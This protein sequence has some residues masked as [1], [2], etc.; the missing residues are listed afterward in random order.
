[1][2]EAAER[3]ASSSLCLHDFQIS[4]ETG[5]LPSTPPLAN[6]PGEH[7]APW[8]EVLTSLPELNRTRQLRS[9]VHELP[10]REFS[11]ATLGSEE[12]WR[13][14]YVVLCFIGQSYIWG[15]GQAGLVDTIPKKL[16]VPWCTVSDHLHVKPVVCYAITVLYNFQLREP[17]GPWD[18]ENI[19]I[20]NTFTGSED[21]SWFYV[22]P[23]LIELAAVPGINAMSKVFADMAHHR[24]ADILNCLQSVQRSLQDMRKALARMFEKCK[25]IT[26]YTEIR[27][28][29]AGT[30]GLDVLPEGILFEGV[31]PKPRQYHGASA[32]QTAVIHAFDIFLGVKHSGSEEDFLVT[33]RTHMPQKHEQFLDR[34]A[35]MPPIREYCKNSRDIGLIESYNTAVEEFVKFRSDHVILVTR[36]IVNQQQHSINPALNT[37][38]SGGT[39]FMQF[40]KRVRNAT[41]ELLITL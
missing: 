9:A 28:F 5:F 37:K 29:Q 41:K 16:A 17:L 39:D 26:F 30:K 19:S 25:P 35:A 10:E 31:D 22:V 4:P 12:E 7:F 6:L 11:A 40:L 34:L 20:T 15:E 21:E 32:G 33:M 23:L 24:I 14:A 8:E 18:A 3:E 1:M 27:P 36:Y 13:R 2:A 38:G